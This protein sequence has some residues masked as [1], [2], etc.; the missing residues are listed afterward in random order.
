MRVL[1]TGASGFAGS[2]L[3]PRLRSDGHAVRALA[4]DPARVEQALARL[5]HSPDGA[6]PD[7]EVITGDALTGAG[8]EQALDGVDVAYYL[9]HSMERSPAGSA[10]F[11]ERELVAAERFGE[12]AAQAA[13]RRIVYLGG[14]VPRWSEM[15]NAAGLQGG[16]TSR[17]GGPATS[18]AA[19]RLSASSSMRCPIRLHCARRS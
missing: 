9:I 1:V 11:T 6:G 17:L 10:P 4:R 3:V 14:L 2:L 13:V 12:Q 5:E 8:L 7:L 18:K 15:A 19:R 16:G